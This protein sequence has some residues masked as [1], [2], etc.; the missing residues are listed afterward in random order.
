MNPRT[1]PDPGRL[2]FLVIVLVGALAGWLL[3]ALRVHG[4]V[5]NDKRAA[6]ANTAWAQG[7]L[8]RGEILPLGTG[9]LY[10]NDVLVAPP[11]VGCCRVSTKGAGGY[12]MPPHPTLSGSQSIICQLTPGRPIFRLGG[13]G[14]ILTEPL[15]LW[16]GGT[17]AAIEVEGRAFPATGRHRFANLVF[18][19]WQTAFKALSGNYFD[20]EGKRRFREEE[21]HADNCS[22]EH[23]EEFDCGTWFVSQNQQAVNWSFEYCVSNSFAPPKLHRLA[24]LERGGLVTFDHHVFC[25]PQVRLFRVRDYSPNCAKLV[26]TNFEFDRQ[27]TPDVEL[28]PIEYVGPP[29]AANYADYVLEVSG[30]GCQR[31]NL[32]PKVPGDMPRKRWS[33]DYQTIYTN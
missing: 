33:I 26:C 1:S 3:E 22:V 13:A 8:D 29:E 32:V 28:T 24:D 2:A 19:N 27:L 6:A 14:A 23:C 5:Y 4:E 18:Y 31:L 21:Q 7:Y 30:F 17:A 20:D 11:K 15:G 10:I 16:G 12:Y 25:T 9:V